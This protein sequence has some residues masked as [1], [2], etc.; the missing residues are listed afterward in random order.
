MPLLRTYLVD[1]PIDDG[2]VEIVAAQVGVAGRGNHLHEAPTHLRSK[3][4][5]GT[6]TQR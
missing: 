3:Q 5:T 6:Y 2:G 1:K 4:T